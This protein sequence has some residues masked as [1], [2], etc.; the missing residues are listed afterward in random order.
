VGLRPPVPEV[1]LSITRVVGRFLADAPE[2]HTPAL[3]RALPYLL[4]M[5]A[6]VAAA[7]QQGGSNQAQGVVGQD[8][9]MEDAAVRFLTPGLL[10]VRE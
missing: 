1:V 9:G 10:Q 5:R 7:R 4:D 6:V 3:R 2:A 8:E